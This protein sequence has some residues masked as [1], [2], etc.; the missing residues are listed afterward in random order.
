MSLPGA[1]GAVPSETPDDTWMVDGAVRAVRI[2]GGN[3]WIGGDF[4]RLLDAGGTDRRPA[5]RIAALDLATGVP[6]TM[7]SPPALDSGTK[8][9]V[10]DIAFGPDGVL[11]VTGTFLYRFDGRDRRNTVGIDPTTGAVVRGFSTLAGR[12]VT[13]RDGRIYVGGSRLRAYEAATG[14]ADAAFTGVVPG[15]DT[16]IRAPDASAQILDLE[17]LPN[18]DL[19][20][21]GHF[22][23]LNGTTRKVVAAIDPRSGAVRDWGI[24]HVGPSSKAFGIAVAVVDGELFVGAGGSDF[25]A[26]YEPP[27]AGSDETIWQQ[28]WKTD[29][30]GSAQAIAV[31]D[32]ETVLVGGHFKR[33]APGPREQCGSN[34]L[35]I[36]SCLDVPRLAALDRATGVTD[37]TWRPDPC[38]HYMGVWTLAVSGTS[39][40]AGGLFTSVGGTMQRFYARLSP[41]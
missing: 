18:G 20:A 27:P 39:V 41:V 11:Y 3:V 24:E 21:A 16:S 12:A 15:L 26:V 32:S 10:R 13:A 31:Y 9:Q 14:R 37:P 2:A 23:L 40:H 17:F 33:I 6:S 7:A 28:V 29:T 19:V 36:G 25:A 38:C 5:P 35:P 22:D 1:S 8:A 4:S 34:Q 30:S